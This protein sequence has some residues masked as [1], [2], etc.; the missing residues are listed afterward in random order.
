MASSQARKLAIFAQGLIP[1]VSGG[2]PANVTA[3]SDPTFAD[4][5]IKPAS[6]GWIRAAMSAISV[7]LGFVINT[8]SNGYIKLPSFLGGLIIQWG[9]GITA[10]NGT[11]AVTL[12]MAFPTSNIIA[13]V[14]AGIGTGSYNY[15]MPTRTAS[16]IS[17]NAYV[18]NTGALAPSTV[19]YQF[20]TI[21][22]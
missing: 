8:G 19:A 18:S 6:T 15:S 3:A 16:S 22:Y 4:N 5:S 17:I 14:G 20:I 11:A 21:G 10:S 12:P 13:L 9:Q 1:G 2:E 7:A